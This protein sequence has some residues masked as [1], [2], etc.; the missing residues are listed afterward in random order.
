MIWGNTMDGSA[1]DSN[2][3]YKNGGGTQGSRNL[4]HIM[5][6][7]WV[8]SL[9]CMVGRIQGCKSVNNSAG[10]EYPQD[11]SLFVFHL[12]NLRFHSFPHH[13]ILELQDPPI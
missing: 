12:Q 5:G 6:G 8:G 11:N 13:P 3:G 1:D 2:E 9:D 4:E 10:K 7:R